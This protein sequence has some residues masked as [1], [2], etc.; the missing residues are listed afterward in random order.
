MLWWDEAY[1]EVQ[2]RSETALAAGAGCDLLVTIGTSGPAALP[3]AIAAQAVLGAE[4]TLID[5]NPDDNPYAEHAQMLAEEGR[6]LALRSNQRAA[7]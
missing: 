5:I 6:G 7:R 2:Y 4:A 3:Y 1:N